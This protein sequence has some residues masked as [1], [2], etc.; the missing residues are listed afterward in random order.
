MTRWLS[1]HFRSVILAFILLALG[2]LG[3]VGGGL[4][5]G[6]R[7]GRGVVVVWHRGLGTAGAGIPARAL[8]LTGLIEWSGALLE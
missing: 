7:L 2:G 8:L 5:R 6:G 3:G 4:A 1:G